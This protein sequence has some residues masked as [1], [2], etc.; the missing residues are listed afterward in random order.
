[1]AIKRRMSVEHVDAFPAGAY[2]VGEVEP[3]ADFNAAQ[4]SDGSRPQAADPESG[5]LVWSVPVLDADPEAGKRD[6]TINVKVSAR[7]Q[8]VPPENT[9]GTP[10][11]LVEFEGLTATPWID[12]NGPRARMAWSLRATG[13]RAPEQKP[14][15]ASVS[16]PEVEKRAS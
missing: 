9:S 6:K 11:T 2:L 5:L 8:P 7:V 10:F 12:D 1:M 16:K 15:A 13:I 4:R 3:V 14:S